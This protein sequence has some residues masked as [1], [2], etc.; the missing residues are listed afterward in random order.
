M[1]TGEP[2]TVGKTQ[3][4]VLVELLSD[5]LVPYSGNLTPYFLRK[6]LFP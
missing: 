6:H 2:Q 5:S 1:D 4:Q 3:E